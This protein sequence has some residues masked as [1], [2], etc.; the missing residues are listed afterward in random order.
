[1]VWAV[2]ED[3]GSWSMS[4]EAQESSSTSSHVHIVLNIGESG[5]LNKLLEEIQSRS[6]Y[7]INVQSGSGVQE[8]SCGLS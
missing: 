6:G 8:R 2:I 1:L 3:A 4:S 5:I 7:D